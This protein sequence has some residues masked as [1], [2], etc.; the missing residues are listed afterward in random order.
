MSST[1]KRISWGVVLSAITF[2]AG[3]QLKGCNA[4]MAYENR[5]TT[6]EQTEKQ[7][8]DEYRQLREDL[9]EIRADV[10]HLLERR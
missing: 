5:I 6:V 2:V 4:A 8:T 3:M 7:H 1:Q 9:S 10:K